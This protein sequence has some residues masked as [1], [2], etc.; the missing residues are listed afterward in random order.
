MRISAAGFLIVL[1]ALI[2]A[3]CK[4]DSLYYQIHHAPGTYL[5]SG[6]YSNTNINPPFAVTSVPVA[7]DTLIVTKASSNSLFIAYPANSSTMEVK[8][9][10]GT[11][12]Q[13]STDNSFVCTVSFSTNNPII[14]TA[15]F[16]ERSLHPSGYN[17]SGP[18]IK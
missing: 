11:T 1:L 16:E 18:K 5:V 3:G 7:T 10:D 15:S 13:S 14:I 12:F 2:F 8:Y 9:Q 6:T 17:L 4:K